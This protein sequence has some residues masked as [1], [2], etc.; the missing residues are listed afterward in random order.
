MTF[1][2]GYGFFLEPHNSIDISVQDNI[3][4]WMSLEYDQPDRSVCSQVSNSFCGGGGGGGA[5]N[6][7]CYQVFVTNVY[8]FLKVEPFYQACY[9][10]TGC[11]HDVR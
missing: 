2:G 10:A 3:S 8:S 9:L 6:F 4:L 5:Q 7:S 11:F 1:Y